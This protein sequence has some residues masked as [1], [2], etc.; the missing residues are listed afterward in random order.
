MPVRRLDAPRHDV[1]QR[2]LA[3][4]IR[5]D[6][7]EPSAG[8][9]QQIDA[10]EHDTIAVAL[11]DP[12]EFDD[13]IAE[14]RG[15]DVEQQGI[16]AHADRLWSAGDDLP[17]RAQPGLGFRRPSRGATLQP[18]QLASRQDP[19]RRLLRR[20]LAHGVRHVQP[21]KWRKRWI[22]RRRDG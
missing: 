16:A 19:T 2:R 7:A 5:S 8:F 3:G 10:L 22:R 21:S 17:R 13:L 12:S 15:T 14:P 1:E 6:D 18:C 20:R 9:D 4:T 11:T